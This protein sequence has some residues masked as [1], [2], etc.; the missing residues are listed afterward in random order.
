MCLN[1]TGRMVRSTL[2]QWYLHRCSRCYRRQSLLLLFFVIIF[3]YFCECFFVSN[4]FFFDFRKPSKRNRNSILIGFSNM[5]LFGY[6]YCLFVD[7]LWTWRSVHVDSHF[8]ES[9]RTYASCDIL[10]RLP[11]FSDSVI[12]AWTRETMH[13]TYGRY[14]DG[15]PCT[16]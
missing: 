16:V 7:L 15:V 6:E 12:M 4:C 3:D 8:D 5:L 13:I 14:H 10:N 11:V 2:N 9:Y 1:G